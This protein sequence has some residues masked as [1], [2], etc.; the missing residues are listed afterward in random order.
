MSSTL[1]LR[2]LML[3]LAFAGPIAA[4]DAKPSPSASPAGTAR[5]AVEPASFD[6]GTALPDKTLHKEFSIRNFGR[7]D[8][9]IESISTT[10]GCTVGQLETKV[11]KAGA[12]VPLRVT[13]ETRSYSGPIQ[14]SVLIRSNDP[15]KGLF[16]IKL[17]VDVQPA[18]TA[19]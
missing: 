5:I 17:Q 7:G 8:L 14:R 13:L 18:P 9:V 16:E 12:S 3:A 10:C 1:D 11:V 6:F 19:K 2:W 15:A 4:Q